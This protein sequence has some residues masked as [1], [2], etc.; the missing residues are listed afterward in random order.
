M[1]CKE[2]SIGIVWDSFSPTSRNAQMAF[3]EYLDLEAEVARVT[4]VTE[5]IYI[6]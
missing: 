3:M 6:L 5:F 4:G 2:S 1:N